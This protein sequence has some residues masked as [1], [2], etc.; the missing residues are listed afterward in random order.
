MNKIFITIFITYKY[1]NKP[2]Y[3]KSYQLKKMIS[4]G[5]VEIGCHGHSHKSL[6]NLTE[7]D[8]IKEIQI[9]KIKLEKE[10]NIRVKYLSFPNGRYDKNTVNFCKKI[11][12]DNLF[13]SNLRN[14]DKIQSNYI[15]PRICVYS[16]DNKLI[17]NFKAEGRFNNFGINPNE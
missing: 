17:V 10:F 7:N 11:K 1:L 5:L 14:I 9:P 4:S 8:L 16:F 6:I 2:N 3:L 13:N 12:F 15:L